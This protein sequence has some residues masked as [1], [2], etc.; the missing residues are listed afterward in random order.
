MRKLEVIVLNAQDSIDAYLAGADRLELVSSMEHGGLSPE[1]SIVKKVVNS[2]TIPVNVMIRFKPQD[3][4]YS[5][6]QMRELITYIEAIKDLG[7]NG[8]VFGSL[9]QEGN[10]NLSQLTEIMA[11]AGNLD[12]TF[13]RAIDEVQDKYLE[14][15]HKI[16]GLVTTVLTSGGLEKPILD[17]V[18]LL[19]EIA[20]GQTRVLVGG[21]ITDQN[22]QQV[23][24][25][26]ANCDFHV[27]SLA[28]VNGDF[29]S[30]IDQAAISKIKSLLLSQT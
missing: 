30:G 16:D 26:L 7:I 28:Y 11:A 21:G 23:V 22:Y 6:E 14:N 2:V 5:P 15:F 29:N 17:N 18:S 9:D 8:V 20:Q 27:G 3:F 10:V 24:T 4:V 1:V 13:H 12:I 19:N 25:G